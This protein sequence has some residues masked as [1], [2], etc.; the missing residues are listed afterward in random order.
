[1]GWDFCETK[2]VK[3]RKDHRCVFCGRG[4]SKG[5]VILHWHGMYEGDFQNSY[6]CHWCEEHQGSLTDMDNEILEDMSTCLAEDVFCDELK[7]FGTVYVEINTDWFIF[8]LHDTDEE[9]HREYCP[10]IK[11]EGK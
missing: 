8:K 1:M 3:T 10:V 11:T 7:D 5:N 9:V 4:I 6:A 2:H